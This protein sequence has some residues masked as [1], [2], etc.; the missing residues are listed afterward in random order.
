[1]TQSLAFMERITVQVRCIPRKLECRVQV[2]L[3][4]AVAQHMNAHERDWL[5][6]RTCLSITHIPTLR[7]FCYLYE[8]Q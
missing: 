5:E 6:V 8:D 3:Q 4:R 1:M 2:V 7:A